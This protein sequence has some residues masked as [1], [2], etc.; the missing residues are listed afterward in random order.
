M[1]LKKM[2]ISINH[3]TLTMDDL[4]PW[5]SMNISEVLATTGSII[6]AFWNIIR[7]DGIVSNLSI[8]TIDGQELSS[9]VKHVLKKFSMEIEWILYEWER[10]G[11]T[12]KIKQWHKT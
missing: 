9:P 11:E 3:R 5:L 2:K 6:Y 10:E 7:K 4:N 1:N 8:E 12:W